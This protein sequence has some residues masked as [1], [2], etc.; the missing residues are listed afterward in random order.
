MSTKEDHYCV[1][2]DM[3]M[4]QPYYVLNKKKDVM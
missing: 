2:I 4:A 3:E 1:I